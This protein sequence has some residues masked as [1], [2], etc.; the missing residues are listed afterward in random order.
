MAA[1]TGRS[2]LALVGGAVL[3]LLNRK[4]LLEAARM[5]FPK[6]IGS[7]KEHPPQKTLAGVAVLWACDKLVGR[8][9]RAIGSPFP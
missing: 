4:G 8:L 7:A 1:L 2:S 9:L 5:P 6:R 3:L